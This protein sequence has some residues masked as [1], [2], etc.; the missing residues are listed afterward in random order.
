[1]SHNSVNNKRI[2]KNTIILY[3]RMFLMMVI[4]LYTSRV[5][6]NALG[7]EDYGVNNVVAGFVSMFS[8]VTA[9][10]TTAISRF[11]TIEIG[12]GDEKQ[13]NKIF[14]TSI[15][16]QLML[17]CFLLI[18]METFGLWF[19]N[20]KLIIPD[21]R[22]LAANWVYQLSVFSFIINLL[23]VPYN[24]L[25]VAH[26]K[27]SAFAYISLFDAIAKLFVAYVLIYNPIDRLIYYSVLVFLIVN[28][29]RVIYTL[30]CKRN[31]PE[32][33]FKFI[34]DKNVTY[35]I[36]GFA[37]WNFLG[38]SSY[39]INTQGIN[40]LINLFFGVTVNA[41][42]GIAISVDTAMRQFVANFFMAINPQITKSYV[43]GNYTSYIML[44]VAIPII[45]EAQY[46]L[47]LWL[48][49]VPEYAV[50]FTQFTVVNIFFD[51]I[52]CNSIITAIYAKGDIRNYQIYMTIS[53]II[54]F[55]I[56]L[57]CY[58][59][60]L[61][62]ETSYVIFLIDF[63]FQIFVRLLLAKH[64]IKL[65]PLE[66]L[67]NVFLRFIPI[68]CL[69]VIVPLVIHNCMKESL[70]RLI[71]LT[72]LSL[73]ITILLEYFIGLTRIEKIYVTNYIKQIPRKFI[74]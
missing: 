19:L 40:I 44:L 52:F 31:F 26:E 74:R 30:Y 49:N 29:Q 24:A 9:S 50:I 65:P 6:L 43:I 14:C 67:K 59:Q 21:D 25:I 12:K 1:M 13:L 23:S 16:V 5:I 2:A 4:S 18:L 3:G 42:R 60:G 36:F 55:P 37:G 51:L 66:Y 71:I 70:Y 35:N 73:L 38:Q 46:I 61:P 15:N 33:R 48:G 56:T 39:I 69:A 32:S 64:L 8:I 28:I 57:I 63:I 7:V 72:L 45:I 22:I 68:V 58:Y 27:M 47:E 62:P 10:L 11:I 41:A 34:F 53:S 54:V 20:N 17:I